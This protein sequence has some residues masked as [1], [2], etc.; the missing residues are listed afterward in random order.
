M[1]K[2]TQW[3][4]FP[5]TLYELL[6]YGYLLTGSLVSLTMDSGLARFWGLVLYG[7]GALVW[8]LRSRHRRRDRPRTNRRHGLFLPGSIY[9]SLPFFYIAIALLLIPLV[10][11]IEALTVGVIFVLLG[12]QRLSLRVR[13]RRHDWIMPG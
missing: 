10:G 4:F 9:E 3:V 12:C 2:E 8:I 7:L 5:Q 1:T 6:P 13:H 11:S